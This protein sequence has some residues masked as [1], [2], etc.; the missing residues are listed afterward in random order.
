MI[1]EKFNIKIN[2]KQFLHN[3]IK[4][5]FTGYLITSLWGLT[6]INFLPGC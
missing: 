6:N 5:T 2:T 1:I 4:I 3:T